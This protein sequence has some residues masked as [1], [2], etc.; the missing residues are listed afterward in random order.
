M[1]QLP[2]G[3]NLRQL[4]NQAKDLCRACREGDPN[5][6]CRIGLT[7]PRF[8]RLTEAEIV[9]AGIGLA[10]AQLV[11][12]RELGF[13]TWPK[14]KKHVESLSQSRVSMHKL[15]TADDLQAQCRRRVVPRLSLGLARCENFGP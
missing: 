6:I 8:S 9:A 15:V 14:L 10:E 4:R 7:H 5:A 1:R 3:T 2:T 13:D 12:A 11:I